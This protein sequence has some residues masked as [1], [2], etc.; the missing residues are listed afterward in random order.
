MWTSRLD[1]YPRRQSFKESDAY[2]DY[3]ILCNEFGVQKR[4]NNEEYQED[5]YDIDNDNETELNLSGVTDASLD[6]IE[7]PKHYVEY[8][9][10]Q[11]RAF[12]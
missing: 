10:I 5:D 6:L 12:N 4:G 2:S 1:L 8:H 7:Q 11:K 9:Q 3:L